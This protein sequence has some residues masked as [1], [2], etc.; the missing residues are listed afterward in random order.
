MSL[1]LICT[2]DAT[3]EVL[4]KLRLDRMI[5]EKTSNDSVQR[6]SVLL[7]GICAKIRFSA[8]GHET[9]RLSSTGGSLVE[10]CPY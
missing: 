1:R 2:L 5:P 3:L 6:F 10:H 7:R 8:V 9:D 4:G